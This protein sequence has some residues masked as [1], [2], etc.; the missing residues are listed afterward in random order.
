MQNEIV[1]AI[2]ST[3]TKEKLALLGVEQ[4]IMTP[5]SFDARIAKEA[6]I[7]RELTKAANIQPQ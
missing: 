7:A 1:K 4:M 3:A 5:E 6:I 2:N